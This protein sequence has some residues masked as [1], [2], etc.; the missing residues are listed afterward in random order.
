MSASIRISGGQGD[1]LSVTE[2]IADRQVTDL[3]SRYD[4]RAILIGISVVLLNTFFWAAAD[5]AAQYLTES[6]P[7]LQITFLRYC[8]HF[9]FLLPLFRGG[10]RKAVNTHHLGLQILRGIFAAFSAIFFIVGLNMIPV[11]DATAV[12][13]IAPFVIMAAAALI[14]KEH[15]G[16]RR[17]IAAIIGLVGVLI[18]VQPGTDAFHWSALLP[19]AAATCGASA[20]VITRMMPQEDPKVTMIY[21]GAVGVVL[22][23][24]ATLFSWSPPNVTD[25][26]I[27]FLVGLFGALANFTQ[28]WVY[29][30]LPAAILAPFSYAQ[31]V[32]ASLLGFLV[33]GIWPTTAT[34]IG[35]LIIA[36]SGIYSA[37]REQVEARPKSN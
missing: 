36:V 19:A 37:Y 7:A 15:V 26:L 3:I 23:G 17:W 18:I 32:W 24:F 34:L 11:A 9:M 27:A 22:C 21:T 1:D 31:L 4:R 28:I 20:I 2:Q 33:F 16:L 13:F 10:L 8:F 5:T 25:L 29:R 35:A 6:L 14:L 12:T 30:R